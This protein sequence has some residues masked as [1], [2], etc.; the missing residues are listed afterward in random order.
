MAHGELCVQREQLQP[1]GY[2]S[3]EAIGKVAERGLGMETNITWHPPTYPVMF[4]R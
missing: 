3:R 2:Q 1:M 4:R